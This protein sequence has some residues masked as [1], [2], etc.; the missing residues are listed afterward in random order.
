M[1]ESDVRMRGVRDYLCVEPF[2]RGFVEARA[3]ATAFELGF[4]DLM[5]GLSPATRAE[6]ARRWS[7]DARGLE[8][9]LALLAAG[10]VVEEQAGGVALT[11]GFRRSL[12]YR[13]LL[14]AKLAFAH[15]A[16]PDVLELFTALI[17][18]PDRFQRAARMFALFDY[19]RSQE[20]TPAAL[21]HTQRWVRLTTVLTRYEA[22]VCLQIQPCHDARSVLDIGGNS[23]EFALQMCRRVPGLRATIVDLPAVCRIGEA[24]VRP[25]AEASRIT[26]RPADALT[27]ALPTG[28]D[29]VTFKSVLHDWPEREARQLLRRA[30]GCLEPGG[31]LLIF[32]RG[33][34]EPGG[35]PLPFSLLPYLLFARTFRSPQPYMAELEALGF[36]EI[37]TR[38]V[39]LE[40]PFF[41]VT[42]TKTG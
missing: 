30:S 10:G 42:A 35:Q 36:R 8:L 14:E 28:F 23:G 40:T 5:A 31:R 22:P 41:L 20:V 2:L 3:L 13:D 1:S 26:F 12:R 34:L 25:E 21:A 16:V 39:E 6:I 17:Q 7:G 11:P 15:A 33:P 9:L 4:I 29:L 38:R 19:R 18:S 24:H 32:E 37:A 27:D